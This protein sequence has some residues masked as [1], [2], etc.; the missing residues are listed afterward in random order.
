MKI[1]GSDEIV[2]VRM[3]A[4]VCEPVL[5]GERTQSISKV[6]ADSAK[7]ALPDYIEPIPLVTNLYK[8]RDR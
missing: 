6:L 7:S 3:C 2:G 1:A 4:S 8:V 5:H